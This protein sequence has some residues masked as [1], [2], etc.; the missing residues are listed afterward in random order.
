MVDLLDEV[1][2]DLK[3]EQTM[4]LIKKYG[5]YTI[6]VMGFILFAMTGNLWWKS[7]QESKIYKEGGEFLVAVLKMRANKLDEAI[8]ELKILAND[9][10]TTYGA[11]ANLNIA[12]FQQAKKEYDKAAA[13]YKLVMDYANTPHLLA[14]YSELMYLKARLSNSADNKLEL[15][16][17]LKTFVQNKSTFKPSALEI[18][19]ALQ[20]E[21]NLMQEAKETLNHLSTDTNIPATMKARVEQL[22]NYVS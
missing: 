9:G 3:Q 18:L 7:Y 20:I 19:A 16:K 17:H 8:N 10:Q 14:E 15:L 13:S 12:S 6:V 4:G 2:A 22:M 1:R 5:T 11:L 21:L